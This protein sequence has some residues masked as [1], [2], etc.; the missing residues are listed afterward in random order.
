MSTTATQ[1]RTPVRQRPVWAVWAQLV[2]HAAIVAALLCLAVANINARR[3][4]SEMTDGV[5]WSLD[6]NQVVAGEVLEESPAGRAS[7]QVG[8]ILLDISG[9]PI[10]TP[11]DVV[12]VLHGS[13]RGESL[14]KL[15]EGGEPSN[16]PTNP[17]APVTATLVAIAPS[18]RKC[19]TSS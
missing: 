11:R 3:T 2:A 12:D 13:D 6:A 18:R 7:V 16:A 9:R 5:L 19:A 14:T 17:V 8:D 10:D 15:S 1:I 4:F